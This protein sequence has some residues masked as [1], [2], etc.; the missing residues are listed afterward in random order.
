M[1]RCLKGIRV[2]RCLP[3]ITMLLM[4][5]TVL[6][7]KLFR[8]GPIPLQ[9]WHPLTPQGN[10][11]GPAEDFWS[12]LIGGTVTGIAQCN[13]DQLAVQRLLT[14]KDLPSCQRS[15]LQNWGIQLI[16]N[17]LTFG[18]GVV[19]YAYYA[20]R[21]LDP[22]SDPQVRVGEDTCLLVL[23]PSTVPA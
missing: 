20:Q 23:A 17:V 19:I 13:T 22:V 12:I 8:R 5:G 21:G 7:L 2:P 6:V 15:V 18:M 11:T 3:S 14:I 9:G 10:Y 1:P 16:M 4:A